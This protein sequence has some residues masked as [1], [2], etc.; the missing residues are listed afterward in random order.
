MIR[1]PSSTQKNERAT[2]TIK[3]DK[4][5]KDIVRRSL[6][7]FVKSN[8]VYAGRNDTKSGSG[9]KNSSLGSV[10]M[11]TQV[12]TT[13]TA[14]ST[15][16]VKELKDLKDLKNIDIQIGQATQVDKPNKDIKEVNKPTTHV[17]KQDSSLDLPLYMQKILVISM[18]PER[19]KFMYSRAKAWKKYLE[20][21]P[22]TNGS[23]INV[24]QW[25]LANKITKRA[26]Q[27]MRRG[28]FGCAESH[29]RAW[30]KIYLSGHPYG[31]VAEDDANI[32]PAKI[33]VALLNTTL[34]ELEVLTDSDFKTLGLDRKTVADEKS[35]R[36]TP[37]EQVIKKILGDNY[38]ASAVTTPAD[39]SQNWQWHMLYLE[40]RNV[41]S[42]MN[43]LNRVTDHTFIPSK[44]QCLYM[45]ILTREG[46]KRLIEH[47]LPFDRPVDV[48]VAEMS[49]TDK[50]TAL[51][52]TPALAR[53][54]NY[55]SDTNSIR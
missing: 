15:N 52:M 21:L 35:S 50:I 18:R 1:I 16:A 10:S 44:C 37:V 41:F 19:I 36:F 32:E 31:V 11:M 12:P 30:I 39:N 54:H 3:Q 40:Y 2:G 27:K 5:N 34:M 17:K 43:R 4:D 42:S 25:L 46:A 28:Q 49:D 33:R 24:Q 9:K 47:A 22:A 51:C 29:L 45:Y 13:V 23:F 14:T 55:V 38:T 48:Y 6:Q 7:G 8:D 26:A 53:V 20:V